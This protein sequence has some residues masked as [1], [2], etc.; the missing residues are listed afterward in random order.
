[1]VFFDIDFS[2]LYG[3]VDG[4][5]NFFILVFVIIYAIMFFIIQY[6]LIKLYLYL[7]KSVYNITIFLKSHT[8]AQTRQEI[9]N[10]FNNV[11]N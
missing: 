11:V 1:M 4:I 10:K 5:T 9:K 7:G 3:M 2:W 8:I 6:Y